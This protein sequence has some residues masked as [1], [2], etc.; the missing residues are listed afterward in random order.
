MTHGGFDIVRLPRVTST[1]E[2]ARMYARTGCPSGTVIL[3]NEQTAGRGRDGRTWESAPGLGLWLSL[4]HRTRR[5]AAEWPVATCVAALGVALACDQA[6]IDAGIKWP[7]DVWF[8]GRKAA[9][10]LADTDA[11]TLLI[12]IGINVLHDGSDFSAEIRPIAT[13]IAIERRRRGLP[14][15]D[16]QEY[17]DALLGTLGTLLDHFESDGPRQLLPAVWER[18]VARDRR[19]A[20]SLPSGD[21]LEGRAVGLGPAGELRIR[22]QDE[23]TDIT[24][25]RLAI[26]EEI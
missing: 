22:H 12:G 24:S 26:L 14:P 9:G 1:Q 19:V 13:S 10:V 4:V 2:V 18:S 7:N 16:R 17:L 6:G 15:T 5:P 8:S 11:S 23:F 20:V 21:L 25:G 3:T